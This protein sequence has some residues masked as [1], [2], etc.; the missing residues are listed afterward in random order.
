MEEF[1]KGGTLSVGR[2]IEERAPLIL[3][4]FIYSIKLE[5]E[6]FGL[7]VQ[8]RSAFSYSLTKIKTHFKG[9][10]HEPEQTPHPQGNSAHHKAQD[11][12][13]ILIA[14][15]IKPLSLAPQ[16]T[17]ERTA[18]QTNEDH[19]IRPSNLISG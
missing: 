17:T 13:Q 7:L 1:F 3:K 6:G 5:Q 15:K 4:P 11:R 14:I 12:G 2:L 19:E 9:I 8:N 18:K 10:R 16:Q